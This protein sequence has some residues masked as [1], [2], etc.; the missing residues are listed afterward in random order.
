MAAFLQ[1]GDASDGCRYVPRTGH[2]EPYFRHV[3]ALCQTASDAAV[4]TLAVDAGVN[5]FTPHVESD[6]REFAPGLTRS[7]RNAEARGPETS[8]GPLLTRPAVVTVESGWNLESET[9]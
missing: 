9:F 2:N 8:R 5:A 3:N 7:S 6:P 1:Y 4:W